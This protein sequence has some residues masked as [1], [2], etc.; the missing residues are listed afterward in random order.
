MLALIQA[1]CWSY[2]GS[3]L[4]QS[5]LHC[6]DT[7]AWKWLNGKTPKGQTERG[8]RLHTLSVILTIFFIVAIFFLSI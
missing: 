2:P 4:V 3:V 5:A 7:S 6:P 1:L 8:W